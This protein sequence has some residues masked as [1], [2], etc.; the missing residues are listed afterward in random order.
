MLV[1]VLS[2]LA[3]FGVWTALSW[4]VP[5]YPISY[6]TM[7]LGDPLVALSTT[8][9][10]I[11]DAL[12]SV[13][14]AFVGAAIV[15][16]AIIYCRG[17]RIVVI[18]RIVVFLGLLAV[19]W[20]LA[21]SMS[22][23][24]KANNYSLRY[25]AV[26][27]LAMAGMVTLPLLALAAQSGRLA[28]QYWATLYLVAFLYQVC[29]APV[30][31][32]EY[33]VINRTAPNVAF[34][35]SQGIKYIAGDYWDVWPAVF[36]LLNRGKPSFGLAAR[37]EGNFHH[38]IA[39]INEDLKQDIIPKAL[40]VSETYETCARWASHITGYTWVPPK[41]PCPELSCRIITMKVND[42]ESQ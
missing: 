29:R 19:G 3:I 16:R 20:W 4:R 24:V 38:L 31:L 14:F 41:L 13:F 7:A 1:L 27:L 6:F 23:W 10:H 34:A 35:D 17:L 9:R 36:Q 5:S 39:S 8:A 33:T 25:F 42:R 30:P 11:Y 12:S 22:S 37:G 2:A 28:K 32:D 18:D 21:F 40:C 26:T 15:A